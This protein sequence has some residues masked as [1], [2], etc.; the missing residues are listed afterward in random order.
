M[1]IYWI[2]FF[3]VSVLALRYSNANPPYLRLSGYRTHILDSAS[4]FLI[5]IVGF[6]YQVGGDWSAYA[7]LVEHFEGRPLSAIKTYEVGYAFFS[8]LGANLIG[9]VFLPNLI[10]ALIFVLGL[11]KFCLELP[12][13]FLAMTVAVPYLV[14]VVAQGYTKQSAAIGCFL[15]ASAAIQANQTK[16]Y[17]L[18][19]VLGVLFHKTS[20]ILV[21]FG[22][23]LQSRK[24]SKTNLIWFLVICVVL[25]LVFYLFFLENMWSLSRYYLTD[26]YKSAGAEVRLIMTGVS[27][28]FFLMFARYFRVTLIQ[29]RFWKIFSLGAVVLACLVWVL[30]YSTILDRL[31]LYWFPVQ[32]FVLGQLPYIFSTKKGDSRKLIIVFI[33]LL[34]SLIQWIWFFYGN[35]VDYWLPYRFYPWELLWQSTGG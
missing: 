7:S 6:R 34:S 5:F 31:G 11:R 19:T 18:T 28:L 24:F 4:L 17:L 29:E 33:V 20:V 16:N 10:C 27:G 3:C 8:W 23:L 35:S 21:P 25:L 2:F 1:T 14:W 32:I 30:P 26:R 12:N 13:P 22:L 9:G 15:F